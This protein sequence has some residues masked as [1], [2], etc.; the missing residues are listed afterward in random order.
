[1]KVVSPLKPP[2]GVSMQATAL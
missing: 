1:L 2:R